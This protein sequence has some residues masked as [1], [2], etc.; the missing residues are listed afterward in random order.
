M[1]TKHLLILLLVGIGM[2]ANAQT[3][4]V[5]GKKN[6]EL[7]IPGGDRISIRVPNQWTHKVIQPDPSLPPT[8][9]IASPADSVSLQITFMPDPDGLFST[10]EGVDRAV[11]SA[12]RRYVEGSVEKKIDLI[13]LDSKAVRGC[14]STFTDAKAAA[15]KAPKKGEFVK[16]TSG[17]FVVQK[18]GAVFTL[19]S[20][21]TTSADYKIALRTMTEDVSKP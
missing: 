19:L 18:Q 13:Q 17:V 5:P 1:K 20:N 6:V 16:V 14:Y 9:K 2:F 4:L 7:A 12:N 11:T 10:K 3:T 21:D 15:A 8:I